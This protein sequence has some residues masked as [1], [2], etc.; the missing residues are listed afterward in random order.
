MSDRWK[1]AIGVVV[2]VVVVTGIGLLRWSGVVYWASGGE[3]GWSLGTYVYEIL[4]W[5]SEAYRAD[6]GWE[7]AACEDAECTAHLK[8]QLADD[9]GDGVPDRGVIEMPE[10]GILGAGH[11]IGRFGPGRGARFG[12][13]LGLTRGRPFGHTLAPFRIVGGLFRLALLGGVIA[14]GVVLYRRRR[15]AQPMPPAS[16]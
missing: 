14:L 3:R 4:G 16:A 6:F 12:R 8:V 11:I 7:P 5:G 10:G 15:K 1:V 2:A 13:R 9:D